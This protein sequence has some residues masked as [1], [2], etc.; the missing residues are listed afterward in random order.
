MLRAR[1]L[2]ALALAGCCPATVAKTTPTPP[3]KEDIVQPTAIV[4]VTE[5]RIDGGTLAIAVNGA[6]AGTEGFEVRRVGDEFVLENHVDATFLGTEIRGRGELFLDGRGRPLRGS[7][8]MSV[9][10]VAIATSITGGPDAM[11][12]TIKSGDAAAREQRASGPV[13]MYL[14]STSFAFLAGLCSVDA[15]QVTAFPG[16]QMARGATREAG[17]VRAITFAAGGMLSLDV[18]CDGMRFL[19]VDVP[20]QGVTV[21]RTGE[22]TRVA[23]LRRAPRAKPELPAGL[24]EL[25]RTVDVP[26]GPGVE[27]AKLGCSL[28]LPESHKDV[29]ARAKK[30]PTRALAGVI[31]ITGSGTQD[32]DED[33]YGPAGLKMSIFK[34][35]AIELGKAGIASLRCDDRGAGASTGSL[36]NVTLET[37]AA[38]AAATMAALRREPAVNP[39]KTGI[40]G[41]SEGGIIAPLVTLSLSPKPRALVLMAGTGRGFDVIIDEQAQRA[42]VRAGT[43]EAEIT[44]EMKKRRAIYEAMRAG[45]PLPADVSPAEAK[46]WTQ[47]QAWIVSH[48]KHDPAATAAKVKGVAAFIAQGAL[49]QQVAVADADALETALKKQNKVVQKKVYP[50]LNHLFAATKTGDM[51]E[52]SDPEATV[53]ATFLADVVRFLTANL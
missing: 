38:D 32:R 19:G 12:V 21:T 7:Q 53:D 17:D 44:A 29:T 40:V 33:S 46:E 11:V 15:P 43:P 35:V 10:G 28:L 45:K 3:D 14:D 16:I 26:A 39:V 47:N 5:Q 41:H 13:D 31:F 51:S 1:T 37:Y 18:Y 48:L 30:G 4:E 9:G 52:Y 27:P 50:E 20:I 24:V 34:T 2:L 42:L 49:D 8:T 36:D 6:P 25:E 23:A 22:E